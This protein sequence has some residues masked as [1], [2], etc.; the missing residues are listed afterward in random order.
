MSS[1]DNHKSPVKKDEV[2]TKPKKDNKKPVTKEEKDTKKTPRKSTKTSKPQETEEE[3][4]EKVGF[5]YDE[6]FRLSNTKVCQKSG[7]K[8]K[9]YLGIREIYEKDGKYQLGK[10]GINMNQ[11]EF[12]IFSEHFNDI[13]EWMK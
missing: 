5:E 7:F 2:E 3:F 11:D 6:I 1:E 4:K 9:T 12:A 8:G 10:K 13:K